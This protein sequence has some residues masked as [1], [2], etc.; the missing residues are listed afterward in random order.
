VGGLWIPLKADNRPR[1]LAEWE[2]Y[3]ADGWHALVSG[4][5]DVSVVDAHGALH[6]R[7]ISQHWTHMVTGLT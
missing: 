2:I 1:G 3:T 6:L 4:A 7:Q 5:L